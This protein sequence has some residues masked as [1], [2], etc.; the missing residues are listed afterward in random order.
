MADTQKGRVRAQS[1]EYGIEQPDVLIDREAFMTAAT[2]L[3]QASDSASETL[4]LRPL[5]DNIN[6]R[7]F[8]DRI[9]A[10]IRWEIPSGTVTVF[11][12]IGRPLLANDSPIHGDFVEATRLLA[13][14]DHQSALPLLIRCA[15][16]GHEDGHLLLNHLLKRLNDDR[17]HHYV[18]RFNQHIG[19]HR[20]VPAACYYPDTRVI[21]IHP[22][23]GER[24]APQFVLKYL[25]FHECCH[26]LIPT[27]A[28]NP[29]PPAFMAREM[30]APGRK[31]AL[32]WLEKEGF[33]TLPLRADDA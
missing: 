26:Q 16:A 19:S 4:E 22:Y 9:H 2:A 13:R 28:T 20:A 18:K 29:H 10:E 33:P 32:E 1:V 5:F 11:T 24:K 23:I 7:F 21:A 6:R 8:D 14:N 31:R 27:E 3:Q 15:D 25:I 12:G 30:R 17:W